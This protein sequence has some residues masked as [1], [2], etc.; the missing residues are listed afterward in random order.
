M[1]RI[2]NRSLLILSIG[3]TSL[4][5]IYCGK[6]Q[7]KESPVVAKVGTETFTLDEL[8]EV[9][10]ENSGLEI[11]SVQVQNYLKRWIETELVY[12]QAIANGFDKKA[13]IQ[14]GVQKV[15]RDY[16]V[17]KYLEENIDQDLEVTDAEIEEFYK[18][19]STEFVR[20]EDYYNVN[21][22][23]V[24]TYR[25]ANA[26]IDALNQGEP[27]AKLASTHSI[28]ESREKN[29]SLGW[30]TTSQLPP[31]I[32]ERVPYMGLNYKTQI[33]SIHG[34]YIV[35]VTAKRKK[36]EIQAIDEVRDLIVW[37]IKAWKR[38]NKYRRLITYLSENA[39]VETNWNIIKEVIGDSLS[40]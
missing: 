11:S 40:N 2:Y 6:N 29:G 24:N 34:Y 33:R 38:E 25:E 13:E 28:D 18:N 3:I 9:I 21:L 7:Q 35:E 26:I 22:I 20:N 12:H 14:K 37:R 16:I 4:M 15:I 10:P 27:F 23:L 19:N 36:G 32:A 39:D 1:R 30:V 31:N 5:I 8:K 17:V